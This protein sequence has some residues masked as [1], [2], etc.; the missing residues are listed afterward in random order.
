[1]TASSTAMTSSCQDDGGE[2]SA[3]WKAHRLEAWGMMSFGRVEVLKWPTC[4]T[5]EKS[6]RLKVG[7]EREVGTF[8]SVVDLVLGGRR[9]RT[10][11]ATGAVAAVCR[12]FLEV[13]QHNIS[14]WCSPTNATNTTDAIVPSDQVCSCC[15]AACLHITSVAEAWVS[16]RDSFGKVAC[17]PSTNPLGNCDECQNSP[18]Q[19]LVRYYRQVYC[20]KTPNIII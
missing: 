4:Q 20:F 9:G 19:E 1:M 3:Q 6:E 14:A 16:R 7:A 8:E 13:V 5:G 17:R 10:K 18:P 2:V 15:Q 12:C 11:Q